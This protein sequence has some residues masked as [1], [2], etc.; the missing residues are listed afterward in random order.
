M[1]T[2][3]HKVEKKRLQQE[4]RIH[5]K[6]KNPTTRGKYIGKAEDQPLKYVYL[7]TKKCMNIKRQKM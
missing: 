3:F 1:L 7:K 5:R 2:D 6:G 4:I